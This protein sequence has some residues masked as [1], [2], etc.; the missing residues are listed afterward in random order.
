[1]SFPTFLHCT[2][3]DAATFSGSLPFT[4][5]S[6]AM[7]SYSWRQRDEYNPSAFLDFSIGNIRNHAIATFCWGNQ[8]NYKGEKSQKTKSLLYDW[9]FKL[10]KE[11]WQIFEEWFFGQAFTVFFWRKQTLTFGDFS[12]NPERPDLLRLRL[13]LPQHVGVALISKPLKWK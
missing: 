3:L 6:W 13:L 11:P 12:G 9:D 4:P 8:R 2:V 5:G 7:G 1:M 10:Q